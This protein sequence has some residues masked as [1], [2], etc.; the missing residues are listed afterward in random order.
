MEQQN[1]KVGIIG[2]GVIGSTFGRWLKEYTACQV[3]ISDP[4]KGINDDLTGCTIFFIG[5]H[6]PTEADGTQ[7]L[8]LLKSIIRGLP[9]GPVVI[10]TTMLPGTC[11]A[12]TQEL[13]REVIF[14]PE[15][16]TERTAYDDFCHQDVIIAGARDILDSIFVSKHRMYMNNIEAEITKY[17]HNVFGAVA[18]TYFNGIYDLCGRCGADYE[19]VRKGFLLSGY[20]SPTHTHVPGPDGKTGYGGKCFPKDVNAF[21]EY[22]KDI[23]LGELL[24]MVAHQNKY[25]RK[26]D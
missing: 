16:L 9:E 2:Y 19:H 7:D 1:I 6:I 18:V 25:Y 23:P 3:A 5:I 14:M 10:R 20:I 13:G 21:A 15:F 4:P 8:T 26:D 24:K 22:T 12:L 17:A 11:D